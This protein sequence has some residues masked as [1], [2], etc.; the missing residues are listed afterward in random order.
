M[1]LKKI[2]KDI[3]LYITE[4][5][6]IVSQKYDIEEK[7]LLQI[8]NADKNPKKRKISAYQN[9]SSKIRPQIKEEHPNFTFGEISK[10][11]SLRWKDLTVE[12]KKI[13]ESH[14]S[15]NDSQNKYSDM[16]VKDLKQM[17]KAYNLKKSGK[18]SDIIAR[19][20]ENDKTS[21]SKK[22]SPLSEYSGKH[23]PSFSHIMSDD[24]SILS[25]I[26]D[27]SQI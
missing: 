13:F 7:E 21:S 18:K 12:Q 17:C 26:T 19:L 16:T 4:F 23:S 9:F 27:N 1:L 8:W 11:I 14:K 10:T 20:I 6:K 22:N 2:S 25:E 24:G 3:D 5:C 15:E